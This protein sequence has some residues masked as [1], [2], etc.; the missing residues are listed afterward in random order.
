VTALTLCFRSLVALLL[1]AVLFIPIRRFAFPGGNLFELEPYRVVLVA[2]AVLWLVTLLID[3]SVRLRR[4]GFEAPLALYAVAIAGSLLANRHRLETLETAVVKQVFLFATFL[5]ALYFVVSVIRGL[6]EVSRL[7]QLLV[8]GG[9]VVAV[10]AIIE[11]LSGEN[12]FNRLTALP[13]FNLVGAPETFPRGG[14]LRAYGSAQHPIALGA[15]LVVLL[16]L[17]VYLARWS[18]R[19]WWLATA[20]LTA[21]ALATISRT[22]VI[23]LAAALTVIVWLRPRENWRLVPALVATILVVS[24]VLPGT[25]DTLRALFLPEG[26]VSSEVSANARLTDFAPAA[27]EFSRQPLFGQGFGTRVV[28]GPEANAIFLDDQ[29]LQT[30]LENGL[31]GLL[32]LAW[33]FALFLFRTVRAGRLDHSERGFLLSALA[34]SGAAFAAGMITFDAFSFVQVTFLMVMLFGFGS[35][36]LRQPQRALR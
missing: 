22:A 27:E 13:L 4:S 2:A 10:L 24:V 35:V 11:S 17:S 32:A 28:A 30:T 5:V 16:P 21:G 31:V 9:S 20:V 25:L 34:A 26:G 19:R 12:L 7:C 1:L 29:W 23:M 6:D 14:Q 36:L 33:L 3:P 18:S 8:A 15:M